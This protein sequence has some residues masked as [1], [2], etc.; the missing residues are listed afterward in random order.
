[1]VVQLTKLM[2]KVYEFTTIGTPQER[3]KRGT[4]LINV[5]PKFRGLQQ[6]KRSG[7]I[8]RKSNRRRKNNGKRNKNRDRR[9][10]S[11]SLVKINSPRFKLFET[12]PLLKDKE[13]FY[14]YSNV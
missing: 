1:M 13:Y 9:A 7:Q 8:R 14:D 5:A 10:I 12:M 3:Q 6:R 4:K 2:E 11:K